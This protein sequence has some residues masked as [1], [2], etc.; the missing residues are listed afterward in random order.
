MKLLN[1]FELSQLAEP[2]PNAHTW[3]FDDF[4]TKIVLIYVSY[5]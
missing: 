2:K 4:Y 5:K 3:I 1:I